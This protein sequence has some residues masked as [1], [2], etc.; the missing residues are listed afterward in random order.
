MTSQKAQMCPAP[1]RIG[2]HDRAVSPLRVESRRPGTSAIGHKRTYYD[3]KSAFE[4]RL[5][6]LQQLGSFGAQF[7]LIK[8]SCETVSHNFLEWQMGFLQGYSMLLTPAAI[9]GTIDDALNN[10]LPRTAPMTT[11][12]LFWP[13]NET[14]TL[15]FDNG[16]LGSDASPPSVLASRLHT[17]GIRISLADHTVGQSSKQVLQYGA[18]VFEY[19]ENATVRRSI[20]AMNDGGKWVFGQE[21][22]AFPFEDNNSYKARLA[23]DRFPKT[24]LLHYLQKLN[25]SLDGTQLSRFEHGPGKLFVKS[26]QMSRDLTEFYD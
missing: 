24:L 21:G 16:R 17:D 1:A 23:R 26:G 22:T 13:L 12:Y 7:G 18:T 3:F 15:Y 11:K 4:V 8:G 25:A 6:H 5:M 19:F 9:E 14:W 2:F 10:L 20:F